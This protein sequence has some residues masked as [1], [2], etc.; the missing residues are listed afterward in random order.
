LRVILFRGWVILIHITSDS[1]TVMCVGE[2]VTEPIQHRSTRDSVAHVSSVDHV[3]GSIRVC[4]ACPATM[5]G[6]EWPVRLLWFLLAALHHTDIKRAHSVR[7]A[8]A[9]AIL[10]LSGWLVGFTADAHGSGSCGMRPIR[11]LDLRLP[12]PTVKQIHE[13]RMPSAACVTGATLAA[14]PVGISHQEAS[15]VKGTR[16]HP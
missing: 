10:W 4:S 14:T 5:T 8:H 3:A 6:I 16:F 15:G 13:H 7:S 1:G 2:H 12:C 9:V 11:G